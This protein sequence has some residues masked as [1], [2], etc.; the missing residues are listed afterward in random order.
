VDGTLKLQHLGNKRTLATFVHSKSST[1]PTPVSARVGDMPPAAPGGQAGDGDGEEQ[2]GVHTVE[3]CG[4]ASSTLKWCASGGM[5][6][7]LKIWDM[8][9]GECRAMCVHKGGVVALRWHSTLPLIG[10]AALDNVLRLW[11]ARAGGCLR[12]FTGH[13]NMVTSL[14]MLSVHLAATADAQDVM[15]SV[16]DDST[17]KVFH[18]NAAAALAS[19]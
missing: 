13:T 6:R 15:V 16:S 12:E 9:T 10:T 14:D 5:D 8:T 7:T 17:A 18:F 3:C 4:I 11:D 2:E 1:L 19:I